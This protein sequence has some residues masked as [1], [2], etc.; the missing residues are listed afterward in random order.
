MQQTLF[1]IPYEIFGIPVFGFGIALVLWVLVSL[2]VSWWAFRKNGGWK[3][4][5]TTNLLLALA[6]GVLMAFGFPKVGRMAGI[7]IQGYGVMMLLAI[8]CSLGLACLRAPKFGFTNNQVVEMALSMCIPGL[9]GARIFYVVEYWNDMV[10]ETAWQT[11]LNVLCFTE[12]GL[13]VYGSLFGGLLGGVAYLWWKK[14]SGLRMFDLMAP[15]MALGLALGRIGCFLNGC[16]FG[17]VCPDDCQ[18]WGVHF[19]AG[20]PAYARQLEEHQIW[21][22]RDA[23]YYG[24]RFESDDFGMKIA[25]VQPGSL[26]EKHDVQPGDHV[27][28][29]FGQAVTRPEDLIW[30]L[31]FGT[32]YEGCVDFELNRHG[33]TLARRWTTVAP[34]GPVSLA[35]YPTQLYSS[36]NAFLL[37]CVV[38][39]YS[40][41]RRKPEGVG[42]KIDGE[43]LALTLTLYPISRFVLEMI[44]TDETSFLH[45]GLS[46]S[47]NISILLLLASLVFWG[48]LL[49]RA[50]T[51][52]SA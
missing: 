22:H 50:R 5:Y 48:W 6:V 23:F 15:S 37:C 21:L 26:A 33:E 27:E 41:L 49:W 39:I 9:I 10:G 46:I 29:L 18:H 51:S 28:R 31:V 13:V 30:K 32:R 1:F 14:L 25:E 40:R 12:G 20:S 4:E 16:C 47:Q 45:T 44:R 42:L 19:P 36:A 17:G 2:G 34:A 35:V 11:F 3:S 52:K 43:A 8:L 7:P 38:L 24:M